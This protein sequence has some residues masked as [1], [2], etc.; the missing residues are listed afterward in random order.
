MAR[1]EG[2]E[3]PAYSLEGCCSIRL[4]Y[5]RL[6]PFYHCCPADVKI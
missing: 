4:S 6:N 2:L 3:P 1:L 5:R